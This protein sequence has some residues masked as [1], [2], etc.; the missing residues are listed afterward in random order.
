MSTLTRL[1]FLHLRPVFIL[2]LE[3][4]KLRILKTLLAPVQSENIFIR[5]LKKQKQGFWNL[6]LGLERSLVPIPEPLLLSATISEREISNTI[7]AFLQ[8]LHL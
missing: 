1:S 5:T 6:G 4:L 2:V 7:L 3:L 8:S